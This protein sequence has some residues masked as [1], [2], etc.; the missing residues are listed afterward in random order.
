MQNVKFQINSNI[1]KVIT[2]ILIEKNDQT[3]YA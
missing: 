2:N 1:Y 3:H